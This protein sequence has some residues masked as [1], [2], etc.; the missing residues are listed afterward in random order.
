MSC[1]FLSPEIKK[2]DHGT[3]KTPK[4]TVN[5]YHPTSRNGQEAPN[6]NMHRSKSLKSRYMIPALS[7]CSIHHIY[8][9]YFSTCIFEYLQ[10]VPMTCELNL[11]SR[12]PNPQESLCLM[13]RAR[14]FLN[15]HHA[16]ACPCP[17]CYAHC[18]CGFATR[19]QGNTKILMIKLFIIK[20]DICAKTAHSLGV[21]HNS[22]L[23]NTLI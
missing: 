4:M 20:Q 18:Y 1:W 23:L 8:L 16:D 12:Q 9:Q 17:T 3:D 5:F 14:K 15:K 2:G 7:K 21:P 22:K 19:W 13:W 10:V 11:P 6:S